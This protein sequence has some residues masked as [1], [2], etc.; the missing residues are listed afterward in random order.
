MK[1]VLEWGSPFLLMTKYLFFSEKLHYSF[2][3]VAVKR[4]FFQPE[5]S[6][7]TLAYTHVS[8]F[9]LL[10]YLCHNC[11]NSM[12]VVI[13]SYYVQITPVL[14]FSGIDL[15]LRENNVFLYNALHIYLFKN[16]YC[17]FSI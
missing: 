16:R 9:H 5:F 10:P 12:S 14:G 3:I 1:W 15:C 8:I 4:D 13:W 6:E 7:F 17:L 11:A 2:F